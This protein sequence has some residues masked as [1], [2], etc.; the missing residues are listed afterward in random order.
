MK[1]GLEDIRDV[2]ADLPGGAIFLLRIRIEC[3]TF[4]G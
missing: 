2:V 1:D 3:P 4:K